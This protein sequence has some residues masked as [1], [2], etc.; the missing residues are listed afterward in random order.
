M[1][2]IS[3][4]PMFGFVVLAFLLLC[5]ILA[6]AVW[7]ATRGAV[8]AGRSRISGPAGCAIGCALLAVVG[9]GAIAT[10]AVAVVSIPSEWARHGPIG[11]VALQ[12]HDDEGSDVADPDVPSSTSPGSHS[13]GSDSP[14]T[15]SPDQATSV[16]AEIELRPGFEAGPIVSVLRREIGG[17]L[18]IGVQKVQRDGE[19][20]TVITVDV[21]L[22][23]EAQ[24]DLR[25]TLRD[26]KRD[27][28]ELELPSG[29]VIDIRGPND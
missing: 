18:T 4:M 5:T 12:F 26:L 28:P 13:P 21:P 23:A 24:R 19:W 9:L 10:V 14:G 11:R 20:R 22:D 6:F 3:R 7:F 2:A 17:D 1:I 8:D 16:H 29:M 27:A 15:I 25:R